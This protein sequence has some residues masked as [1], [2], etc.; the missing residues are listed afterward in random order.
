METIDINRYSRQSYSIGQDV[1]CK[2]SK[3]NVLIIGYSTL[4]LEIIKNMALLGISSISIHSTNKLSNYQ[5][6]GMYYNYDNNEIPIIELKKL[7]PT[8]NIEQVN[9]YDEDKEIDTN[10]IKKYNLVII[11][12]SIFEDANNLNRITHK[13]N[14]PF[15]MTGCY[16]LMGYLFNDWNDCYTIT[17]V[18]G[19]IYENLLIESIEGK[20]IKFKDVHNLSD[21]DILIV[22]MKTDKETEIIKEIKVKQTKTPLI[23]ELN[24][25]EDEIEKNIK[26]YKN[27]IKKKIPKT[28]KFKSLK[29]NMKNT[30]NINI[31]IG[32]YSVPFE[33]SKDLHEL[34]IAY[35]EYV[36]NNGETPRAWSNVDFEIFCK[37]IKS[38]ETKSKE[39]KILAKKFCFTLR[40]DILPFISIIASI[41][42]HEV[43]KVLG[44]KYNPIVQWY[45]I[46][47]YELIKDDEVLNFK[48]SYSKQ[49]RSKTKYEGIINVFGKNTLNKIQ[50]KRPFVIGSGAIGCELVKNLGM[51]G[52][53]DMFLTD[54]DYIEK[55]NLSRQFLF[56]DNDIRKSKA[57][58]AAKKI[59]L[60]NEDT[61][62]IVFENKVCKETEDIFNKE[63]HKK[64]DVYL[65][66]LDN[67]EA[68]LYVDN[69]AI[70][71]KKPLIDSGTTGGKG[72][73][74]VIIPHLT[75]SYGSSKDPDDKVGIPICTIKSFP[76]K[77]SHTIQWARELFETEFNEIPSKIIKHNTEDNLESFTPS[78]MNTLIKQLY[79]YRDFTLSKEGYYNVLSHIFVENFDYGIKEL[80]NKYSDPEKS[81]ELQ[82]KILPSLLNFDSIKKQIDDFM[83]FGF[84]LMSQLFNTEIIYSKEDFTVL[85]PQSL[86]INYEK[87]HETVD[88]LFIKNIITNISKLNISKKIDFE[89]DD[90]SLGHVEFLL[91]CANIRNN[92]YKIEE[93]DLFTTRKIAGN[94]IPAMITTTALVSGFQIL[95]YIKIIKFFNPNDRKPSKETIEQ[96][97][98]RF[99]N[100]NTNYIDGMTPVP[101][102]ISKF[103]N[104]DFTLWDR[105]E[106]ETNC[107]EKILEEVQKT[108]G[109]KIEYL[110]HGNEVIYDG[111][112]IY[113]HYVDLS[114]VN[115]VSLIEDIATEVPIYLKE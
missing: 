16:G 98:N 110:M 86:N 51:M 82:G 87:I 103:G 30:E 55:S 65:N 61:N 78:E 85:S 40:G 111:E 83:T 28:I 27:I 29:E 20:I 67:Q 112:I 74:Q 62:V 2:L 36:E 31:V 44:H 81:N 37:Y 64:V 57:Q 45:Y 88:M 72:N 21:G 5:K 1:M 76:F 46:D 80:L 107:I 18:D 50:K 91:T 47:Y 96:Y 94:I 9:I 12:N 99:V 52:V 38:W 56:N 109:K 14:I 60:M 10:L 90:D 97:K 23:I 54:M 41:A 49:Y 66:A 105:L 75:E 25:E 34:H 95:E 4:S 53:K 63:F 32:D 100:L 3:A 22:T 114:K 39:F 106:V 42:S 15:I 70:Q 115:L 24:E 7:N 102:P 6:T 101:A 43:L 84:K 77:Q 35:S 13:F 73:V 113:K 89:K 19:E 92:Q 68:R 17:D 93:A 58:T 33:R 69:L 26:C 59:K 108:T 79:K 8:I 104:L 71:N 11:T 48:S